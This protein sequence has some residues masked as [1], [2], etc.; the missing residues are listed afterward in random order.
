MA[1]QRIVNTHFWRDNFILGLRPD[2]RLLFLWVITNPATDLCGAYEAAMPTIELETGL[3]AKRIR[4]IFDTFEA[5]GKILYRDGW[6]IIRNF[7]KHQNGTSTNIKKGVERSLSNCPDWIKDRLSIG[8]KPPER[9]PNQALPEPEPEPEPYG[10]VPPAAVAASEKDPVE[11]RIWTDGKELL[12]KAGMKPDA[13]WAFLGKLA[14]DHGKTN[15]AKAIAVA[16]AENPADP[17]TY[18]VGVL[19]KES[20]AK[21]SMHIGKFDEESPPIEIDLQ[22]CQY[23][24]NPNCLLTH[25]EERRAA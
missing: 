10:G 23:C 18:I 25:D 16:Q 7:S 3:K 8:I 2:E 1:K 4:E 14:K 9:V 17:K 22:P 19:N 11:R 12:T 5:S 15:L 20:K 6:V 24:G 13:S 21:T